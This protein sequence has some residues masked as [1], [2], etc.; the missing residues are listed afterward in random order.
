MAKLSFHEKALSGI[1]VDA[2]HA[3]LAWF[4]P[5]KANWAKWGVE[6]LG[7]VPTPAMLTVATVTVK[8]LS[9]GLEAVNVAMACRPEGVRVSQYL[10]AAGAEGAAHNHLK[11]LCNAGI[12]DA[13]PNGAKTKFATLTEQGI[14]E[15]NR[16]MVVKGLKAAPKVKV[17][18][19]AR[20]R[21]ATP[22]AEVPV[23]QPV[24]EA[25]AA[26]VPQAVTP[27][28]FQALAAQFNS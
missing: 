1:K 28:Q 12:F 7:S 14:S 20:K 10:N 17:V 6:L 21:N 9:P 19:V 8:K 22:V 23:E 5:F 25:P 11:A 27:E 15:V 4:E 24:N 18:K 13:I 26:D 16:L 2:D 3:A